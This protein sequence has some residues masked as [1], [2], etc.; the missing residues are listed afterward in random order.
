[1]SAIL[2]TLSGLH[3]APGKSG[4]IGVYGLGRLSRGLTSGSRWE[5]GT[6]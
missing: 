5:D 6:I 1:M 2:M 3:P 4:G